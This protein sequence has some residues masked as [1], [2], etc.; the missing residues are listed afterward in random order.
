MSTP[1]PEKVAYTLPS[2]QETLPEGHFGPGAFPEAAFAKVQK[3]EEPIKPLM[4]PAPVADAFSRLSMTLQ[5]ILVTAFF[6]LLVSA[7]LASAYMAYTV[8]QQSPVIST[9]QNQEVPY[10]ELPSKTNTNN[11]EGVRSAG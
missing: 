6:F 11:D 9:I 4:V 2:V 5:W 3:L 7:P 8:V 1:S 10:T